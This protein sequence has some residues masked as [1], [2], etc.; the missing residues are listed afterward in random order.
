MKENFVEI[1]LKQA[2][3]VENSK[4]NELAHLANS[5]GD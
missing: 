1:R 4:V 3:R 2:P 5:L